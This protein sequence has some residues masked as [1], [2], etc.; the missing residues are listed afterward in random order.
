MNEP[1]LKNCHYTTIFYYLSE[2]IEAS[3]A[4]MFII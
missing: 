3:V 4:L 1:A 2:I